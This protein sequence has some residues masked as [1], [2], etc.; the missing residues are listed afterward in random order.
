MASK[1]ELLL[2]NLSSKIFSLS[3]EVGAAAAAVVV[4]VVVTIGVVAL[5]LGIDSFGA[6]ERLKE[7]LGNRCE[8]KTD[9]RIMMMLLFVYLVFR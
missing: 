6:T 8:D 1:P 7:L 5:E 9:A 3:E 4:V 2:I